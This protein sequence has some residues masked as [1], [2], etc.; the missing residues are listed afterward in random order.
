MMRN[1]MRLHPALA[2]LMLG[3]SACADASDEELARTLPEREQPEEPV[4]APVTLAT[5]RA[6]VPANDTCTAEQRRALDAPMRLAK[7]LSLRAI[8]LWNSRPQRDFRGARW[9]GAEEDSQ[10]RGHIRAMLAATENYLATGSYTIECSTTRSCTNPRTIAFV[11]IQPRLE[12]VFLCPRFWQLPVDGFNSQMDTL[13]HEFSHLVGT[14]DIVYGLDNC[15]S[16]AET[17]PAVTWHNADTI[18]Y[19][20]ADRGGPAGTPIPPFSEV[21]IR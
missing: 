20:V 7:T 15:L 2:L 6:Q 19:Y 1:D 12:T 21:L 11:Q 16:L 9:F 8:T 3:L 13:V 5:W 17:S 18:A 14:D 4:D 10:Q